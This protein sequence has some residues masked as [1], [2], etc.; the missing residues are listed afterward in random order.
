[1]DAHDARFLETDSI[2]ATRAA[3]RAAR[4]GGRRIGFVPTMGALHAGHARLIETAAAE[5]G[6]AVVSIFVNPTQFGAGEDLSRYPRTPEA[7]LALCRDRG[8]RH[9]FRPSVATLYPGGTIATFVEVP[10]LGDRLEGAARPGHFRG[11]ATVVLKLLNIVQPDVAY[12]GEKDYQQLLVIRRM[13]AELDLPTAIRAVPTV[14]EADGLAMSSRNRYLA[15]GE[16]RAATVLW[17]A[18][19]AA[20]AAVAAGAHDADRVRQ[21]LAESIESEPLARLDYVEVA[22]AETLESLAILDPGR[23]ARAL[24][25]ARVGPARLIDNAPL[26]WLG[27]PT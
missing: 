14:R 27:D 16:R 8:A 19:E 10:G 2:E 13:V 11:V 15:P 1:L 25:A 5:T 21:V 20:C 7:D 22:D 4:G 9:V 26:P 24:V 6:F 18:L 17:H 12:F 3:I 23:A